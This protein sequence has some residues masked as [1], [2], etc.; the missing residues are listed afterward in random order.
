M[1]IKRFNNNASDTLN[2][3][4]TDSATTIT[5]N[6]ASEFP[7]P[8]TNEIAYAT[9]T[10]GTNIEII[11][12]T[13]IS[14][15]DLTGVTRGVDG[16]SGTAFADG[17]TVEQRAIASAYDTPAT[18]FDVNQTTHGFSVGDIVRLSGASTY[19]EAQADSASNAEVAGIVSAVADTDNFTLTT[20]GHVTGLSGLT[21]N[22][23]YFLDPSTAG[24]TTS[25]EPS[26]ANQ[27][28]RPVYIADTTTSAILLPYRGVV[29][30]GK[31]AVTDLADGTDGELITWNASGNPDTVAV[32]TSGHVLTSNGAG[33]APTF[34]AAAGGGSQDWELVA[35]ATASSDASISF[36]GLSST[37]FAYRAVL[38]DIAPATDNVQLWL[39]T[40]TDNGSSYDSGASDYQHVRFGGEMT[41]GASIFLGADNADAQ[42]ILCAG[43]GNATNE[44]A[45]VEILLYNLSASLYANVTWASSFTFKNGNGYALNGSGVRVSAA[46]VDAIQFLLS[47]GNI[48]SGEIRLYG[49]RAS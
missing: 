9:I 20:G 7:T 21:A 32:G 11:T 5:L 3:A 4:I 22:T 23:V 31:I 8:G 17:D 43:I 16:T 34:Q 35:S 27:V 28:S 12:Y 33:A 42:I 6:D 19:T 49:L 29:V 36:T 25:T 10:D 44:A 41:T 14:T 40:S 48:S 24:A 18:Y 2:G 45:N 38:A 13:G 15:N 26:T 1:T 30:G 39:R 47:S 46:D 37:Y